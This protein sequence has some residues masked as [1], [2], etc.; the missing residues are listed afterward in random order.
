MKNEKL[1][2]IF[3]ELT[4]I[5]ANAEKLRSAQDLLLQFVTSQCCVGSSMEEVDCLDCREVIQ[6]A[7]EILRKVDEI[8]LT[9]Y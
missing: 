1:K 7:R 5:R 4:R 6:Q 2:L 9:L 8:Y 3:E